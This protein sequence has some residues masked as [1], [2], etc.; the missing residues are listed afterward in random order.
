MGDGQAEAGV[1][2][3]L[4]LLKVLRGI[5]HG[6]IYQQ[7]GF[8]QPQRPQVCVKQTGSCGFFLKPVVFDGMIHDIHGWRSRKQLFPDKCR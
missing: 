5:K 1:F 2:K 7:W 3:N 6:G 4:W 8:H